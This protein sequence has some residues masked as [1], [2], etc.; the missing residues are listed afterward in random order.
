MNITLIIGNGFDLNL[1]LPTS[2][3]DFYPYYLLEKTEK[4][5]QKE[6]EE[7][8]ADWS[9]LEKQL[10]KISLKYSDYQTYI[11]DIDHV[12]DKLTDYL[13]EVNKIEIPEL[14]QVSQIVYND[15]CDFTRYLDTPQKNDMDRFIASIPNSD[16][17]NLN[18]LTFNYTS[19]FERI[20]ELWAQKL[21]LGRI[22]EV[23]IYHIH[24]QL[25][26]SG[27]L[28]GVNNT[29]QIDNVA[30]HDNYYVKAAIIKPF[31]NSSI[32]SGIDKAC[33]EAIRK[34]H[35]LIVFG[36]SLGVTDQYWWDFIGSSLQANAKRLVYC[37]FDNEHITQTR[38][39][40]IQNRKFSDFVVQRLRQGD[41][42]RSKIITL[43]ERQLFRFPIPPERLQ[44][45]H[46]KIIRQALEDQATTLLL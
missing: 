7:N 15:L 41:A 3:G 12:A 2:Y 29:A 39:L 36:T 40:L 32:Q 8:P 46:S 11:D 28:L 35:I 42:I 14:P 30:F 16:E 9:D 25:D 4:I 26:E 1:G 5:I 27:I 37:P 22:K 31:I 21:Q 23:Q 20:Q 34:S 45:N 10:G 6:L 19:V 44:Q 13:K 38:K 24:Q 17:I 33:Q 18:V 43:R